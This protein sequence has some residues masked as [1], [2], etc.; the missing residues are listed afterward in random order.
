MIC[1][2]SLLECS[3]RARNTFSARENFKSVVGDILQLTNLDTNSAINFDRAMS[4]GNCTTYSNPQWGACQVFFN[5]ISVLSDASTGK[6]II[7]IP[8]ATATGHYVFLTNSFVVFGFENVRMRS[9][10][11][12]GLMIINNGN[13]QSFQPTAE[14]RATANRI[15]GSSLNQ[16]TFMCSFREHL[17]LF[18]SI[19]IGQ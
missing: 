13:V 6:R 16:Q 2:Y 11:V 9:T 12:V 1:L 8:L 3:F 5:R 4:I 10:N 18:S 17:P 14:D 19:S 15:L 7:G